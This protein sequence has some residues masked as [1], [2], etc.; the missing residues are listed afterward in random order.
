MHF[1]LLIQSIHLTVYTQKHLVTACKSLPPQSNPPLPLAAGWLFQPPPATLVLLLLS[2]PQL[3]PPDPPPLV[4]FNP[5]LEEFSDVLQP[6]GK[7]ELS[8]Y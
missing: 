7:V 1:I 6:L 5:P 4:Q 8:I 2:P 3:M